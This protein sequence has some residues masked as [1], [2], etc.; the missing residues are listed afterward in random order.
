MKNRYKGNYEVSKIGLSD[1]ADCG[2]EWSGM[3]IFNLGNW[4]KWVC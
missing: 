3:T 2:N 4:Q 1:C